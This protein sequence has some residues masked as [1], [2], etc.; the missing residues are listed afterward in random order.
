ME[1]PATQIL[2]IWKHDRQTALFVL[3]ILKLKN[4]GNHLLSG[5]CD[6]AQSMLTSQEVEVALKWMYR[7]IFTSESH[8]SVNRTASVAGLLFL[9]IAGYLPLHSSLKWP[10]A[11]KQLCL[12]KTGKKTP[13]ID[14]LS[15]SL[16]EPP[17]LDEW[18]CEASVWLSASVDPLEENWFMLWNNT[19]WSTQPNNSCPY[20]PVPQW[21]MGR[22]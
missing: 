15:L 14:F 9:E 6:G 10:S 21:I 16:K 18:I 12:F 20:D 8:L 17:P 22:L 2:Y 11:W 1:L 4:N 19:Y 5:K 3:V 13:H 7:G